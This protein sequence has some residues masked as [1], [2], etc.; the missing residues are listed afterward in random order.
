LW[1]SRKP[2]PQLVVLPARILWVPLMDAG[3][4][5]WKTL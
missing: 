3:E 2:F 1:S 5:R 4:R